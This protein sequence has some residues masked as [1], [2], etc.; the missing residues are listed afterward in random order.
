M[1]YSVRALTHLHP[2]LFHEAAHDV[3]L[4]AA[5]ECDDLGMQTL[6]VHLDLLAG[7]LG[8]EVRGRAAIV[9]GRQR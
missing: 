3:V 9:Q 1:V 8:D 4:H 6:S 7:D 2:L 5:V